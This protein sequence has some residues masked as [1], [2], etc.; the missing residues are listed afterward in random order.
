MT[1]DGKLS[2]FLH[3]GFWQPMDTLRDKTMLEEHWASGNAPWVRTFT[4]A[5]R[6]IVRNDDIGGGVTP[7]NA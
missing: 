4:A 3:R 7:R 2:A 5:G 1:A 6:P